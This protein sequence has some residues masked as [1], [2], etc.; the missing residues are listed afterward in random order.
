[1]IKANMID[2]DGTNHV[3]LALTHANLVLLK[4]DGLE[5]HIEIDLTEFGVPGVIVYITCGAT[6][7]DIVKAMWPLITPKTTIKD[8]RKKKH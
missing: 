5:G 2:G 4:A 1:M 8:T 7:G 3:M 6:E